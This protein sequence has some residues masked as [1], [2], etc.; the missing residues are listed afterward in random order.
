MFLQKTAHIKT[1]F[2]FATAKV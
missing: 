1:H 2:Y